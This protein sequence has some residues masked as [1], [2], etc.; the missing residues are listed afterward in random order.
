MPIITLL[1]DFG[2]TDSYVA[3]MKGVLLSGAPTVTLVDLT[4]EIPPGDIRA[5]AYVLGRTWSRFPAGTVHLAVVDPGVGSSRAA[6][7]LSAHGHCFVGP[8]NGVFTSVFH[9]AEVEAIAL[10]VPPAASATFHGRDL[11]APAAAAL[12]EGADL[13]SLGQRFAG[14]PHRLAYTSP[15]REGAFVVG[16]IV[17]VDRFGTLITNL[18][19]ELVPARAT[20]QVDELEI[21]PL[22]RTFS[23]VPTGSL[24][25]YI[26]SG[27]TLE[28]AVRDGSATERL[29]VGMG[30][31][32][33]AGP[34]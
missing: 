12:A 11:F 2:S 19:T 27:G 15:H 14:I 5:A 4:H 30:A 25:V 23:D 10:P 32:V 3:E 21:G 20:V 16:E 13:S 6:L 8:D 18:R 29:E 22:Q 28:I 33:R 34:G 1:T 24:L 9:D 31:R 26:G 17:Y 7:G